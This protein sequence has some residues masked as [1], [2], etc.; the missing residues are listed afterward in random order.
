MKSNRRTKKTRKKAQ[1]ELAALTAAGLRISADGRLWDAKDWP[2]TRKYAERALRDMASVIDNQ[3]YV[4]SSV[5]VDALRAIPAGPW[6]VYRG[7]GLTP[8]TLSNLL[9]RF[10]VR[11]KQFKVA[12]K[13]A[14]GYA[15]EDIGSAVASIAG[16]M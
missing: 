10:G 2:R 16:S 7:D 5:A 8:I 9:S 1:G 4:L 6:R 14:R 3:R 12:G 11:P 15:R 13:V